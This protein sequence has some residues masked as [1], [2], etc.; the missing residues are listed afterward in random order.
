[1]EGETIIMKFS[2]LVAAYNVESYIE[3]TIECI[4]KS[5]YENYEIIIYDDCST[6]CT[7]E[8][9][10]KYENFEKVYC[11]HGKTNRGISFVRNKLISLSKGEY[12]I[13]VDGDD[14]IS[15]DLLRKLNNCISNSSKPDI[16]HYNIKTIEKSKQ[17]ENKYCVFNNI[18]GRNAFVELFE[19][20]Y[21]ISESPCTYAI[22]SDYYKKTKYS[23]LEGTV[24]EDFRIIPLLVFNADFV[25]SINFDGYFYIKRSNSITTKKD[26]LY[27]IKKVKDM[28][29]HFDFHISEMNQNNTYE[30]KYKKVFLNFSANS[31][32]EIFNTIEKKNRKV[33]LD[34]NLKVNIL[35]NIYPKTIKQWIKKMIM[36]ININLYISWFITR[37][38]NE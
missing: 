19:K 21:N 30:F 3:D 32:I 20:N 13:F 10:K 24:H 29:Q 27:N 14:I 33:L 34:K 28:I 37:R 22:K 26:K 5:D 9:L 23:F 25:T 17:K 35:K 1:M 36:I 15:S 7:K 11:Y 6:D 12:F 18:D 2:V 16:I 31:L 4:L 8:K 38:E